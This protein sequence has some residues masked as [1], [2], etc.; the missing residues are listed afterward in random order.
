MIA[1]GRAVGLGRGLEE[2]C[3]R[4]LREPDA[5]IGHRKT[6]PEVGGRFVFFRCPHNDFALFSK[7]HGIAD[8]IGEDLPKPAGITPE[9]LRYVAVYKR[10]QFKAFRLRPLGQKLDGWFDGSSP[11]V[12]QGLKV[13]LTRLDLGE[14]EDV[15]NYGQKRIGA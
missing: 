15:L 2:A 9:L 5:R 10:G 12:V 1:G 8:E 14:V 3:V 7:L 11:I 6:D 13:E 4:R